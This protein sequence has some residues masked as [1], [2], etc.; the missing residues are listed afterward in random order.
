MTRI[1][2]RECTQFVTLVDPRVDLV[3]RAESGGSQL[4]SCVA[5]VNHHPP[6]LLYIAL[7]PLPRQRHLDRVANTS[8]NRAL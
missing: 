1:V 3:L 2:R 5:A 6:A 8:P 4:R 7:S